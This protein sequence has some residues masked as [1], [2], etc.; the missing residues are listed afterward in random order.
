MHGGVLV[1]LCAAALPLRLQRV[2]RLV[3]LT[4]GR[5]LRVA[6]IGCDHGA[7]AISLSQSAQAGAARILAVDAAAK[8]LAGAVENAAAALGD[9]STRS[10][11]SFRHVELRNDLEFRLG[12][13]LHAL[14]EGE[15][16]CVTISGVGVRTTFEI[17]RHEDGEGEPGRALRERGISR[18]VLQ[19][20]ANPRPTALR[21]LRG[22]LSAAGFKPLSDQ[23]DL[24]GR[25]HYVTLVFARREGSARGPMGREFALLGGR[26]DWDAAVA[27]GYA[28]HHFDWL[29]Q[30]V[31]HM[32]RWGA[33]CRW[34]DR[35]GVLDAAGERAYARELAGEAASA[36][37]TELIATADLRVLEEAA[38]GSAGVG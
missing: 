9:C 5:P 30:D 31:E 20:G 22:W 28:M 23:I 29:K 1:L 10:G 38:K 32:Q 3:L 27:A 34:G 15:V 2:E 25:R 26:A 13:G 14:Q 17:L 18:L 21:T 24:I 11:P 12:N 6:D 8:A 35:V 7:L 36:T 4:S 33:S 16:H 37:F 19:P